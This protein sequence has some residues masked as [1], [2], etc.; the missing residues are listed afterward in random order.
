MRTKPPFLIYRSFLLTGAGICCVG[1]VAVETALAQIEEI[2]VTARRK[3]ESLQS[4]PLAVSAF[5][6]RALEVRGITD[7]AELANFTPNATFDTT[8]TFS[9][10]SSTFQGFIRGIG[11]SDFAIN[12]DPG[13]GVYID[14]IY[15][16]RTVGGVFSL[17]DVEQVEVLKGPQGTLFGRNTIGGAVNIRTKRPD[18]EFSVEGSLAYGRF[19]MINGDIA[20]NVPVADGLYASI[21]ASF[22]QQD[23]FQE[24]IQYT[25]PNAANVLPLGRRNVSDNNGDDPGALDNQSV[26]AKVLWEASDDLTL[27]ASADYSRIRDAAPPGTLVALASTLLNPDQNPRELAP[28][29]LPTLFNGCLT[30]S[31]IPS[32]AGFPPVCG[33]VPGL[34]DRN[35]DA[36]PTNDLPFYDERFLTDNIDETFATGANFSNIDSYGF[37]L[38][39]EWQVTD[40]IQIK[41]ITAYRGLEANIGRDIDGS[42]LDIDQTSFIIDQDQI[43]QEIQI[44]GTMFDDRLDFTVGGFYFKED[45]LQIDQVPLAGGLLNIFGPNE[46]S[47][48]AFALFGEA[49]YE[50]VS[51]VNLTFGI[52]YT[53]E[54]K[55]LLLQQQNTTDFFGIVFAG[56]PA[57]AEGDT[58]FPRTNS[59]GSPNLNFL[60]PDGTLSASF[61]DVSIRAGVNWQVTP[62]VFTYFT[63]SQGFKSGGFTTRLTAPF[64]PAFNPDFPLPFQTLSTITFA[65][66]TANNFE[67]GV[68]SDLLDGLARVNAAVF[69]NEY[70]DIQIV[71]QRG[72]TPANENAGDARI[73]GFELETEVYPTPE[74]SLVGSLGYIDAEYTNV[75]P[76]AFPV[77]VGSSLQN[78]PEWTLSGAANYIVPGVFSG[79]GDVIFNVNY[80]WRSG[81]F[82]DAENTPELFQESVGLLGAQV[83][84]ED[85]SGQWAISAI[86]RNITNERFIGAGFNSGAVSFV[87]ASFNRPAEWRLQFDFNF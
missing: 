64:N 39:G 42:P 30:F 31:A 28:G 65:P 57:D 2:T 51:D 24:R 85:E 41:S 19:N 20:A 32:E 43:S 53:D 1:A 76:L 35:I 3:T 29:S 66:E 52:R 38:T 55:D 8:S 21:A 79:A 84:Y 71:V 18:E 60:G 11:Q 5:T 54:K 26:R 47:T 67:I 72:I 50:V 36:D 23:G 49:S 27:I 83:K 9:G 17:Y 56:I 22:R 46:Q 33:L 44:N 59:D 58:V 78:T 69:W 87:E 82:N 25:G 74:L 73:R 37:S 6:E 13:V 10:A 15:I 80:S 16:A 40:E 12:T 14:D 81:V 70:S 4:V 86:G 61:D 77:T 34:Q 48:R 45:A 68:K 7:T 75:D 63:F 62:D